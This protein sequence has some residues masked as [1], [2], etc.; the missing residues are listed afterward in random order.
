M[1][2]HNAMIDYN[3]QKV[4]MTDSCFF[5]HHDC[6]DL[7]L[8]LFA[9][10]DPIAVELEAYGDFLSPLGAKPW[11][12]FL[13]S[14]QN[15]VDPESASSVH[16]ARKQIW[17]TLKGTK[18]NVLP[19]WESVFYHLGTTD[20]YLS[21]LCEL[22]SGLAREVGVARR[23]GTNASDGG[24]GVLSNVRLEDPQRTQLKVGEQV[25]VEWTTVSRNCTR[26][27]IGS[28]SIL[29]NLEIDLA[30]PGL[31]SIPARSYI[32]TVAMDDGF[33]TIAVGVD[34]DLKKTF[35]GDVKLW[36]SRISATDVLSLSGLA[37]PKEPGNSIWNA[38]IWPVLSSRT[39]SF[40]FALGVAKVA[41]DGK[42]RG[43]RAVLREGTRMVSLAEAVAE[44]GVDG[45][46][47]W[48]R[49]V[50]R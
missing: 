25:V 27:E 31:V 6:Y 29:S 1:E 28:R 4:V 32:F 36:D 12:G 10:L 21:H 35:T 50:L 44:K 18:L 43:R 47:S 45:L 14:K 19:M 42:E 15:L 3:G 48:Y 49:S 39:A 8:H 41:S 46:L 40:D 20:E 16:S 30:E 22:E 9:K 24:G 7:F 23:C 38:R 2:S 17:T 37:P 13:E 5:V 11:T 33:V 34:D 26:L